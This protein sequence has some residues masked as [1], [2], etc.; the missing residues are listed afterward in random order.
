MKNNRKGWR[1]TEICAWLIRWEL[2]ALILAAPLLL[3]VGPWSAVGLGLIAAVWI[4]RWGARRPSQSWSG[5]P[6]PGTLLL[7]T[8]LLWTLSPDPGHS[9]AA[10]YRILL[11][12]ALFYGFSVNRPFRRDA[13]LC[14][15]KGAAR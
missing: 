13:A 15:P 14:L 9:L 11:G 4:G 2:P 10:L 3:W 8:L 5:I 12:V 1:F 7:L 6:L